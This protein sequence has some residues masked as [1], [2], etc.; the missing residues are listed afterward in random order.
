MALMC[1]LIDAA[2]NP[3]NEGYIK[4]AGECVNNT[5]LVAGVWCIKS[6]IKYKLAVKGLL[7]CVRTASES[8][9]K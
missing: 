5:A 2:F 8:H 7:F 6:C 4:Y 9:L 3:P 1:H